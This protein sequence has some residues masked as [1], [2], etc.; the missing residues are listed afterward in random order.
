MPEIL[1]LLSDECLELIIE[2]YNMMLTIRYTPANL[3]TSKVIVI[4]K[5]GKDD[6]AIPKAYRPISLT[7]FLF[8]LLERVNATVWAEVLNWA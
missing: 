7:P 8:K 2:L 5:P 4:P 1:K 3:R 6:Y